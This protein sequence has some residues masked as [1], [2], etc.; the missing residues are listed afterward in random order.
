MEKHSAFYCELEKRGFLTTALG[1]WQLS[2]T[3][4]ENKERVRLDTKSSMKSKYQLA[5]PSHYKYGQ[6]PRR[7]V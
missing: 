4:K 6:T 1:V 3:E 5:S 2:S 7:F